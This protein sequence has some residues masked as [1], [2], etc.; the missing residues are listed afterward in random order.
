MTV[1]H[2]LGPLFTDL[3]EL[4]MA[5]GYYN[6]RLFEPATFSLFIRR[7]PPQRNYFVAAGL[8][9]SLQELEKLRF[10]NEDVS[11]LDGTN[12]FP[13]EFLSYLEQFHF[14]GDVYALPEGTIF[15]ANEP[16]L[17]ITAPLIEA[18]IIE[19]FLLNT[20]GFQTLIAS[21]AARCVHSAEGRQLIDF[22]LRRTQGHDAG[23]KVA[24][25]T[26]IA[27]FHGTSNVLAGKEYGL[28]ISGTMA[29]S[30][31]QAFGGDFEAFSSFADIFPDKS[32][33]LIDTF[34]TLDGASE[35]VK[36]ALEMK[37]SGHSLLGVRLDS[38]DMIHLSKQ[39]RILL[40]EAGLEQVKI[41]ASGGYD[42]FKIKE[43]LE[44]GAS[45]DAFG[46][47]TSLGVS[48]DAPFLDI[49]YKL[50]RYGERHVRKFSPGKE[51]LGGDKQVFRF[52]DKKGL[53]HKDVIGFRNERVAN[54]SSLLK[55]AM[56]SGQ[57]IQPYPSLDDIR[58]FFSS[59]FAF[60]PDVYKDIT[61]IENYP[62]VMSPLF[63][64]LQS[65]R[66]P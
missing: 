4:T 61:A 53:Y 12:S 10:S 15:F 14:T 43:V 2:R 48:A 21:K 36:V 46:V 58:Q 25:S 16:I 38:G 59:N 3:Y 64:G 30:Y 9:D 24:R 23:L 8:Q 32:V 33:F 57:M 28:P 17:E 54:G 6:R 47:G 11:F 52:Y 66:T 31:I 18:Q 7:Y 40:D 13:T 42:E 45:I 37:K 41:F 56:L 20:I 44:A 51:T 19:T 65:T 34:D 62:V 55:P 63:R 29:H 27:G 35:A 39:V 5:A 22:S 26:F 1:N 50:V 60:L 49:V